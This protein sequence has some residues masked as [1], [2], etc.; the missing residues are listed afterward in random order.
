[1]FVPVL[2]SH[3]SVTLPAA[4]AEEQ[5]K[6]ENVPT[7]I[8]VRTPTIARCQTPVLDNISPVPLAYRLPKPWQDA[9]VYR[10]KG[11]GARSGWVSEPGKTF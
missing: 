11:A 5:A 1:M 3:A 9:P 6:M 4:T 2:G 10:K 7:R 8:E